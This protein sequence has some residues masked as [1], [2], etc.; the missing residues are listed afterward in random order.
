MTRAQE[1]LPAQIN[2][3]NLPSLRK[4]YQQLLSGKH[5]NRVAEPALWAELEREQAACTA[6]FTALGYELRID[7]RG[8]AWFHSNET[9]TTMTKRT[10]HLALL[11][12][13]LFESHSDAGK[14]LHRFTDWVVDKSVLATIRESYASLLEAEQIDSEGL[15]KLMKTATDFGFASHDQGVWRLLP[16]VHRYLDYFESLAHGRPDDLSEWLEPQLT[17]PASYDES[18]TTGD[19]DPVSDSTTEDNS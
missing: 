8:F 12:L 19:D 2:L 13:I 4:L 9:N 1:K 16:A 11:F 10:R 14:L 18:A 3:D 17:D 5:I 7:G 15:L 6:L